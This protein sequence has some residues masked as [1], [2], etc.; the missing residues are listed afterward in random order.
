VFNESFG[1]FFFVRLCVGRCDVIICLKLKSIGSFDFLPSID[2]SREH[3]WGLSLWISSL[4]IN[5]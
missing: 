1:S 2:W 4:R 3:E 5:N